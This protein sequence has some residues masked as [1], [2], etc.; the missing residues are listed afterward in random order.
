MAQNS[1]LSG[2]AFYQCFNIGVFE[3]LFVEMA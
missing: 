3:S 1:Y 2:M